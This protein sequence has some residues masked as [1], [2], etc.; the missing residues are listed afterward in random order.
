M[1]CS[2]IIEENREKLEKNMREV[3]REVLESA[4]RMQCSIYIWSD[5]E[6]CDYWDVQGS[7]SFLVP[8]DS[9]KRDLY[10]V[11]TIKEAAGFSFK[12]YLDHEPEE[13]ELEQ[14]EREVI[15]WLMDEYDPYDILNKAIRD[16]KEDEKYEEEKEAYNDNN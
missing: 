9:E 7:N 1:K 14:A 2:E 12:D 11:C 8:R 13:S 15:D 10:H 4:G 16:I 5:G 6:L 3:Y